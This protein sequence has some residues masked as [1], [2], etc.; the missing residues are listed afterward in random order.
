[1]TDQI[2]PID[3][4]REDFRDVVRH[5]RENGLWTDSDEVEIRRLIKS[6]IAG[7]K[8][9][10]SLLECWANWL[11]REAEVIRR[12][13]ARVREVEA[14]IHAEAAERRLAA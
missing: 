5:R 11:H 10:A 9:D 7:R 4:L 2:E 8:D 6:A 12:W 13:R 14:R 1:M 3:A